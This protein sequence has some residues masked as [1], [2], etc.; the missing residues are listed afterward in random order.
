MIA[1]ALFARY[2]SFYKDERVAADHK[3]KSD[4]EAKLNL[5]NDDLLE[6]YQFARI[7]NH[8]QG[9]RLINQ[10]S[11]SYDWDLNLSEIS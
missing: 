11:V 8:Y 7:I 1:S 9:F 3:F 2:I 10:A 5:N 4:F 6:A